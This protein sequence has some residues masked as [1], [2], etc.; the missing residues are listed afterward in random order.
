MCVGGGGI[1]CVHGTALL[2]VRLLLR[3]PSWLGPQPVCLELE[4]VYES[5]TARYPM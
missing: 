5:R 1:R 2:L 4:I 3:A